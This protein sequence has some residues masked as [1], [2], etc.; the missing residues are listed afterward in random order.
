M[1]FAHLATAIGAAAFGLV[2]A[3]SAASAATAYASTTVNLRTGPGT[4]YSVADVLDPGQRVEVDYCKGLWCFVEKPG[5][6]GWVNASY[7]TQDYW[8]DDEEDYEDEYDDGEFYITRPHRPFRPF[9]R[10]Q[11][12]ISGPNASFCITN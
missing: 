1:R 5:P 8:D 7:L 3:T 11:A 6:D 10:S 12:C 4:S 2:L 9:S